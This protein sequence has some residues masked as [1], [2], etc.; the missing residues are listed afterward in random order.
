MKKKFAFIVSLLIF[1]PLSVWAQVSTYSHI[2][3]CDIDTIPKFIKATLALFI[4][5]GV[6]IGAF[7][8]IWARNSGQSRE[9]GTVTIVF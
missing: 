2:V 3:S 1:V 4:Q 6:P 7:F 8:F 9:F 5:V